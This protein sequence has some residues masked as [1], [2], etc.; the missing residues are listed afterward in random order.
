MSPFVLRSVM[1]GQYWPEA[2]RLYHA[3]IAAP[4]LLI[5]GFHD[6][7]VTIDDGMEMATVSFISKAAL[8]AVPVTKSHTNP[9]TS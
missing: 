5:Y 3:Q 1:R 7:F 4:T 9:L 2:D 8:N 6:K